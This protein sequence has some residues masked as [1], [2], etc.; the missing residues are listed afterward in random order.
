MP[1]AAVVKMIDHTRRRRIVTLQVT[2]SGAYPAGGDTLDLSAVT[3]P[4]AFARAGFGSTFIPDKQDVTF[5]DSL[6]GALP[7]WIQGA[8][9]KSCKIKLFSS[10]GT[11]HAAA[12]Y[13]AAELADVLIVEISVPA[14]Q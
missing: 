1:L 6:A 14:G 4:N 10:A 12:A 7:E 2:P 5:K 9:F 3:N 11:E 8:D 13:T